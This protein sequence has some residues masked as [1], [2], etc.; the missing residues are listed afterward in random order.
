[1]VRSSLPDKVR[2]HPQPLDTADVVQFGVRDGQTG[3]GT[4]CG[5]A[6]AADA[7][8]ELLSP[9]SI[10]TFQVSFDVVVV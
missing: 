7:G 10:A 6:A 5:G 3:Y 8:S 1:M 9:A 2:A 4:L